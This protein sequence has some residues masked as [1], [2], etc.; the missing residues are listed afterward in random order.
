M[1]SLNSYLLSISLFCIPFDT[2]S[3]YKIEEFD[4]SET[5][6]ID[7]NTP[8]THNGQA[9]TWKELKV[10]CILKEA[11]RY[12]PLCNK[13]GGVILVTYYLKD[14]EFKKRIIPTEIFEKN[15]AE[16]KVIYYTPDKNH[17]QAPALF[18]MGTQAAQTAEMFKKSLKKFEQGC[19]GL[20][21]KA[22][23]CLPFQK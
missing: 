11:Y 9:M 5:K 22:L 23:N 2:S 13:K 14:K 21:H 3:N 7:V 17:S 10:F 8:F 18:F 19:D 12:T 20:L 15:L 4:G 1:K 16:G 6:H